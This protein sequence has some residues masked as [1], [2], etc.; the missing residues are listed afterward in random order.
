L[1]TRDIGRQAGD[2]EGGR[3]KNP[4]LPLQN[5]VELGR[6]IN[7]VGMHS[8]NVKE[9]KR[10]ETDGKVGYAKREGGLREVNKQVSENERFGTQ[11]TKSLKR[12][13]IARQEARNN[14]LKKELRST[15]SNTP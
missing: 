5:L 6:N 11:E 1:W 8:K 4:Y 3:R 15:V 9:G 2:S 14:H 13:D 10:R 7:R 12:H